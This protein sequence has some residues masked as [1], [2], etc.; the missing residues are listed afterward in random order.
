[1]TPGSRIVFDTST[2]VSVVL[3]PGSVPDRAFSLALRHGVVCACELTIEEL[4]TVLARGKFDRY[5]GKRM[6]AGFVEFLHRNAWICPL[7]ASDVSAVKPS[8]RDRKDNVFLALAAAAE[9]DLIVSSDD[10]LLA[11]HP[12]HD[13]PILSPAEFLSQ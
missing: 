4:R 11:C 8:C 2:L 3:R 13:I 7:S 12:W 1:L 6:R 10:D 9:A 5:L